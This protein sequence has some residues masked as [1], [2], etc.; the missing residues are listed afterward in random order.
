MFELTLAGITNGSLYALVAVGLVL[1]Y[2]G[3]RI[4]NFAHGQFVMLGAYIGMTLHQIVGLPYLVSFLGSVLIVSIMAVGV[5]VLV[6]RPLREAPA[7]AMIIATFVLG[8]IITEAA[9][10]I[11]GPEMYPAAQIISSAPAELFGVKIS[12][13]HIL[14]ITAVYGLVIAM[15][16]FF[17]YTKVGKAMRATSQN[18]KAAS[19][20][21]IKIGRI[22]SVTWAIS[23]GTG[24]VAG[25]LLA[26]LLMI[27]PEMGNIV[28]KGFAAA[29]IGG[30]ESL[31][32]AF[33]GGILLSLI[34][35]FTGVYISLGFKEA[36]SF[37][38]I[39]LILVVKPSGI[40]SEVVGK[41]V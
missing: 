22:F 20:V 4:V 7:M 23:A 30:F 25:L 26:P 9:K 31:G 28:I 18:R 5:D 32:G 24:A 37:G 21:G 27:Q 35:T 1:I 11:W 39:I 13:Q 19:L 17:K 36:I 34:E 40:F 6:G 15:I 29:I 3:T 8:S 38:L 2:K 41:R 33:I 10:S 16:L 14:T 12:Y